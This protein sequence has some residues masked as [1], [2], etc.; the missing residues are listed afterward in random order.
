MWE[1]M[2]SYAMR[3]SDPE[4]PTGRHFGYGWLVVVQRATDVVTAAPWETC[5]LGLA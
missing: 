3:I 2:P 4:I 5:R 1:G